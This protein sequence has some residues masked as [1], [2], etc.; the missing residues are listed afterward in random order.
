MTNENKINEFLNTLETENDPIGYYI[1][2]NEIDDYD[3][4]WDTIQDLME[5]N[6]DVDVI[7]YHTAIDYLKNNDP[8]LTESNGLAAEY[9][10]SPENINSELLASL[11][12]TQKNRESFYDL[13]NE[14]VAF[15]ED[16]DPCNDLEIEFNECTSDNIFEIEV[17]DTRT[18]ETD[19]ITFDISINSGE[20]LAQHV[21][22]T[23]DQED[24]T[25]IAFVSIEIDPD[26]SLDENLQ[27][28][29]TACIEAILESDWFTLVE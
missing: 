23:Q 4:A 7:Y 21:A 24:S 2:A 22:L 6:L 26:F 9:G 13:E 1:D 25:K 19:W 20:F 14:V 29:N 12:A 8:S 11:L 10:Y 15:F 27:E 5:N 17:L 28:L 3:T 18:K 16:L